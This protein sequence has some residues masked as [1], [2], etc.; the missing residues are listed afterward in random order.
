MVGELLKV[1]R[2]LLPTVQTVTVPLTVGA[3]S[4]PAKVTFMLRATVVLAL[5]MAGRY[6]LKT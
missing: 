1:V 3:L 4:S 5:S 2:L 6:P